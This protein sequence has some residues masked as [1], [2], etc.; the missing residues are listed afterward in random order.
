VHHVVKN[1]TLRNNMYYCKLLATKYSRATAFTDS[2]SA[3]YRS[4][5]KKIKIKEI[6]G[7]LFS[8]RAPSENGP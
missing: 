5:K 2:V 1:N 3:V 7:S 6:N 4:P 8:K